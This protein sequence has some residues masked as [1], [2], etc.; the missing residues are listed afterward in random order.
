[1]N[2]LWRNCSLSFTVVIIGGLLGSSKSLDEESL[3]PLKFTMDGNRWPEG[4]LRRRTIFH[5]PWLSR[6]KITKN[7]L[8]TPRHA[9]FEATKYKYWNIAEIQLNVAHSKA[10]PRPTTINMHRYDDH[11]W[12]SSRELFRPARGILVHML[13][14]KLENPNQWS[15]DKL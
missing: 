15:S 9:Q 13:L 11:L 7:K 2:F 5:I 12:R 14:N 3:T 1:M 8:K 6:C 10:L 4:W